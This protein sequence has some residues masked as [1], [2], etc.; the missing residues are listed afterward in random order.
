MAGATPARPIV[1]Y[2]DL[3]NVVFGIGPRGRMNFPELTAELAG[4]GA[5][6]LVSVSTASRWLDPAVDQV[7][8]AGWHV[9]QAPEKAKGNADAALG[10]LAGAFCGIRPPA[11]CILVTSDGPLITDLVWA[12]RIVSPETLVDVWYLPRQI[13]NNWL[14]T[15]NPGVTRCRSI[16]HLV[17]RRG[18]EHT[19]TPP[20]EE[21]TP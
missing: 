3:E 5:S 19:W 4:V 7:R 10:F 1:A 21:T 2:L 11:E 12:I 17:I 16:E 8:T 13:P 6:G 20:S 9:Y 18:D 14:P 15:D